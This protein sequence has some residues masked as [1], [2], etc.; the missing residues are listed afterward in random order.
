M[1]RTKD[2]FFE[3]DKVLRVVRKIN[4]QQNEE[5]R[6][7]I[8]QKS[9]YKNLY[10]SISYAIKPFLIFLCVL[11][12][13]YFG[14]QLLF[15]LTGATGGSAYPHIPL[16]DQIPTLPGFVY[17]YFLT[18]PLGIVTFFYVAYANKNAFR[19]IYRTLLVSFAI[20]GLIYLFAQTYFVKPDF[21]PQTFTEKFM[22]GTWHST[23]PINCF[24]SQHAFM[25]IAII[26][27]CLTSGKG[28]KVWFKVVAIIL[29]ILIIL[30][31]FFLKQHFF[32]DWVA[33]LGIMLV[34]YLFFWLFE[35]IKAK[36]L[37]LKQ[38]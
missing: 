20:S 32:L 12:V 31:T 19:L 5:K 11:G 37:L 16:D 9:T 4:S 2:D 7:K 23:Y 1:K 25:A 24:P 21:V 35:H 6:P 36:K 8:F 28:M 34:T 29:S 14:N 17:P 33:S 30:A 15:R 38:D 27:G 3:D 10:G 22:V 13:T 26:I 18:F